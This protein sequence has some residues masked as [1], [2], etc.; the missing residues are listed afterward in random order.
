MK[1]QEPIPHNYRIQSLNKI[2][3]ISSLVL[4]MLTFA[5]VA[6]DYV[7]GWKRFQLQFLQLQRDRIEQELREASESQN[8]AELAKLDQQIEA[9][10]RVIAQNREQFRA[11]QESLEDWEGRHY[12]ADQDYRFAKAV[13]DA[14]RYEAELSQQQHHGPGQGDH[15]TEQAREYRR[16]LDRVNRL[17]LVLEDVTRSRDAAKNRLAM[18]TSRVQQAEDQKEKLTASS[19]L[20]R[21]QLETV[22]TSGRFLLLNSPLLD[23]INPTLKIDQIVVRDMFIDLNYLHAPRVD[24]CTTCHRAIDRPGFESK[25]EA[26][27]LIAELEQKL[28]RFQVDEDKISDTRARI[29]EL[30]KIADARRNLRNPY[31]T[32]PSLDKFVGSA[33]PHPLLE[34]GCTVCHRGLD[35]ATDFARA[36]HMPSSAAQQKK[37]ERVWN[38]KPQPYLE[39]P[40]YPRQYHEASCLKCHAGQVDVPEGPEIN[41][42][43]LMVELYGCHA[44]HKINVW[45]FADLRKPGPDLTGIAEKTT[46][47]WVTRWISEPHDFRSTTRMPSFFF[48]RNMVGPAVPADERRENVLKQNVEI[49]SIVAYLFKHSTRRQWTGG[50]GGDAGR[51]KLIVENVG[52]LGCHVNTDTVK[53]A[54]G[55]TRPARRDDFPLERNFG[56]NLTGTGTK[57]HP[58]WL[59]NWLKNPKNYY[60]EAPMPDLRLT[61]QEAA[62]VTAYLM[63]LQKPAFMSKPIPPISRGVLRELAETYMTSTMSVR[64]ARAKL[65]TMPLNEQLVFLGQ[66]TIEKYGCYS[67]HEIKGFENAKPIGTELTT[68]GS[69][70]LHLFDFGFVHDYKAHDGTEEHILHTVASWIYNKVRSPRVYDDKREKVYQD[71][72][73]MP[74]YYL[75]KAE[76]EAITAVVLGMTKDRVAQNRLAAQDARDRIVEEGRKRISQHNCRGCHVVGGTGRAIATVMEEPALLPPDLTPEGDRVQSDWLFNFLKDPT[77][78]TM[79]PWLTVRMPTFHFT[80]AEANRLVQYFAAEGEEPAFD[81]T[82]RITPPARNVAIGQVIFDM[83]KCVQCHQT[84]GPVPQGEWSP[85]DP[86]VIENLASSAPNLQLARPRLRHDW[87]D[88]WIRRPNEMI[89][90]TRMPTNF[91]RDPE[92]AKF[93]SPISLGINTPAFAPQKARLLQFYPSEQELMKAV[94]DVELMTGY[95]RDYIWSLGTD[96]MR[97]PRIEMEVQTLPPPSAPAAVIPTMRSS[98]IENRSSSA[99]T[100]R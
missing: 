72:L 20:L 26:Q 53:D 78:M 23:F 46:P 2:F 49:Q 54:T 39:T 100:S 92:T 76:A 9:Q 63:T 83:L 7:R 88:D 75:T 27:R 11:A 44:C 28:E 31:R 82:K 69:K 97:A 59:F 52:C 8:R 30:R 35:R 84:G 65:D 57:S 77:V 25:Q 89:P 68:E 4:L 24:R 73:K 42:G 12:A 67:C 10:E 99:G 62:D 60:R 47:Q 14:R 36:G 98:R 64:D 13:L 40:M 91:P 80:D 51:G 86:P 18:W 85:L 93:S 1:P 56:F 43:T 22:Q 29:E 79:R 70:N 6:Y 71:K 37:W 38:W 45:R 50:G 16:Q 96:Q 61:D 5:L 33:S 87:I 41:R 3:A 55:V 32:H 58:S 48:Q 19:D 21:K 90:G 74:N 94:E 66:R 34:Y 81:T 17:R 15:E 95:L